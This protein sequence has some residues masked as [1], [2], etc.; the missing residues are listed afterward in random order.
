MFSVTYSPS[1]RKDS[2]R[3]I[4][5]VR[6][7]YSRQLFLPKRIGVIHL[8]IPEVILPI[9]IRDFTHYPAWASYS[10]GISR[11]VPCH[12]ASSSNNRIVS[13]PH[14]DPP[15][16]HAFFWG[17]ANDIVSEHLRSF[18]CHPEWD[19]RILCTSER[20]PSHR[21]VCHPDG[22][23]PDLWCGRFFRLG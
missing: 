11:D 23:T 18:R 20:V 2:H 22:S 5:P 10:Y 21:P 3:T 12:D 7:L 16:Q 9:P 15:E 13:K 4:C 1:K 14:C 8:Q 6:V 17:E 19:N